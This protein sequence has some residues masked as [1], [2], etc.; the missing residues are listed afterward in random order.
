[1]AKQ[2]DKETIEVAG[3]VVS[4]SNPH[5]VLFPATGYTKLD[6]VQDYLA[7]ADGALRGVGG[8]PT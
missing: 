1:M 5:R 4:V 7:V 8:G 3:R 2:S 6:L